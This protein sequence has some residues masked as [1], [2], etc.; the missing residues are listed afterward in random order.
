[1]RA[2]GTDDFSGPPTGPKLAPKV[3]AS[4]PKL[5]HT[6]DDARQQLS[7]NDNADGVSAENE[8][9]PNDRENQHKS[10]RVTITDNHR[11]AERGGLSAIPRFCFDARG[12]RTNFDAKTWGKHT[13][14]ALVLFIGSFFECEVMNLKFAP[15]MHQRCTTIQPAVR[16][17]EFG[18]E[19]SV[20]LRS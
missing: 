1:M 15:T 13:H 4:G 18:A 7:T 20:S 3:W 10:E 8:K 5:A 9:T 2:T 14:H 17:T 16:R 19:T 11:K 12:L 6:A